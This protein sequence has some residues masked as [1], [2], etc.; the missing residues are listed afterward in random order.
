[1]FKQRP[2]MEQCQERRTPWAS[3]R[4]WR[5]MLAAHGSLLEWGAFQA[6]PPW[7]RRTNASGHHDPA[8]PSKLWELEQNPWGFHLNKKCW[9]MSFLSCWALHPNYLLT[10]SISRGAL[11]HSHELLFGQEF[12]VSVQMLNSSSQT[13]F[14]LATM[15][16]Q[17]WH[18]MWR[19]LMEEC[20]LNFLGS[21]AMPVAVAVT[22]LFPLTKAC[23]YYGPRFLLS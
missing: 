11:E 22:A 3:A 20:D 9:G 15:S 8:L 21:R 6:A 17:K 10:V 12:P 4:V 7:H 1:M 18:S 23:I 13:E 19:S 2:P 14:Q 5:G 16:F